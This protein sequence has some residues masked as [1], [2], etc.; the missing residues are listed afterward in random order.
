MEGGSTITLGN[1]N[2]INEEENH[3][4]IKEDIKNDEEEYINILHYS[5][6]DD[7]KVRKIVFYEPINEE[8]VYPN[9]SKA[10]GKNIFIKSKIL[11]KL[12]IEEDINEL[13]LHGCSNLQEMNVKNLKSLTILNCPNL[14]KINGLDIDSIILTNL[15][16]IPKFKINN[17]LKKLNINKI[18]NYFDVNDISQFKNL[19]E[20]II[21]KT[22]IKNLDLINT[23]FLKLKK[24]DFNTINT[25]N[26]LNICNLIELEHFCIH[27]NNLK[28]ID[29]SK[30]ENLTYVSIIKS[31][32]NKIIF[33]KNYK[34]T[35]LLLPDNE[36]IELII[37]EDIKL[38]NLNVNNNSNL[39]K[40]NMNVKNLEE[41]YYNNVPYLEQITYEE[42]LKKIRYPL[43]NIF[44][45]A[46]KKVIELIKTKGH[47]YK[48][49][50][51]C[52]NVEKLS[53]KKF[54]EDDI[55]IIKEYISFENV[56]IRT[57][58]QNN[59]YNF[60]NE[61]LTPTMT[62]KTLKDFYE[63]KIKFMITEDCNNE[64]S[65]LGDTVND[66]LKP[67]LYKF[68]DNGK[69]YCFNILELHEYIEKQS[70][71]NP[72]TRNNLPVED[73]KKEYKKIKKLIIPAAFAVTD[74]LDDIKNTPILSREGII[75]Q[76]LSNIFSQMNY[77]KDVTE[78]MNCP[79]YKFRR[80]LKLFKEYGFNDNFTVSQLELFNH[81]ID[82][83][84]RKEII[85]NIIISLFNIEDDRKVIRRQNLESLLNDES[86]NINEYIDD[87]EAF[88]MGDTEYIKN[89]VETQKLSKENITD[90]L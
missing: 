44:K 45:K 62:C 67:F 71:K 6:D 70:D 88:E 29:I 1:E 87:H 23:N 76:N 21:I 16:N 11:T 80:S 50:I 85:F 51:I 33:G 27:C 61:L 17:N 41:I 5:L 60:N 52:K 40:I 73:I 68:K 84:K 57:D 10:T 24:L 35:E 56:P 43:K 30:N 79:I 25:I 65:M 12:T 55:N 69:I 13:N 72:Y 82:N 77:S 54:T 86:L 58:T 32:L 19:E 39:I 47:I 64:T 15:N 42:L 66:I 36:L 18:L 2:E 26:N 81:E 78:F 63:N 74:I 37:P 49:E 7:D 3:E 89:K 59:F 9:L 75:K 22:E 34:L 53:T 90:M 31:K 28:I 8:F 46:T 20:L 83:Q 14:Q 48:W 4:N 38:K